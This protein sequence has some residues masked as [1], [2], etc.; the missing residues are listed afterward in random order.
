MKKILILFLIYCSSAQYIPIQSLLTIKTLPK[1]VAQTIEGESVTEEILKNGGVVV[2]FRSTCGYCLLEYPTWIKMKSL[3]KD[4]PFVMILHKQSPSSIK[5]FFLTHDNPFDYVIEDSSNILW[6]Q[7]RA[8][9]TPESFIFDHKAKLIGHQGYIRGSTAMLEEKL[10]RIKNA[11]E[12]E[13]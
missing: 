3:H 5:R 1:F 10:N 13:K 7:F 6:D 11:L 9:S 4:L 12:Q 2:F 8:R